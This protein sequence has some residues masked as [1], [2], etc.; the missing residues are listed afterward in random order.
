[1]CVFNFNAGVSSIRAY[2]H[3]DRFIMESE[4]KVDTNQMAYYPGICASRCMCA[5][6]EYDKLL[7]LLRWLYIRLEFVGNLI[8]FFAALFAV[9]K[10]NTGGGLDPGLAGLSITYALQVSQ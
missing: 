8:I 9:I 5:E 6:S 3:Q 2:R 10:R 4:R 1:M 7:V